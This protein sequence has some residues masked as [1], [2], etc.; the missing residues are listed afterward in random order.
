MEGASLFTMSKILTIYFNEEE[1]SKIVVTAQ[2]DGFS[3]PAAYIKSQSLKKQDAIF[4]EL[5]K[6]RNILSSNIPFNK[7]EKLKEKNE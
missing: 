3:T 2:N 5:Q 7:S 4:Q 1:W 6:L